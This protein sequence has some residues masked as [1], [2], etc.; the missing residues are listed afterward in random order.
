MRRS[1]L[2]PS[3]VKNALSPLENKSLDVLGEAEMSVREVQKKIGN[4]PLTS[5]A[6]IM[7]R[8]YKAGLVSRRIEYG[9]GGLR[10]IYRQMKSMET[11]ERSIV[12][13]TVDKLLDKFGKTALSYFEERFGKGVK[14]RV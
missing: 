10:Y 12:E 5:V 9:K 11:F 3:D 7:D 2:I 13:T 8:L 14:K 6:V 4:A 1:R